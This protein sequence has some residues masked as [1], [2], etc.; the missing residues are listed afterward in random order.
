MLAGESQPECQMMSQ[1]IPF[2][3]PEEMEFAIGMRSSFI[4]QCLHEW[5]NTRIF[6]REVESK[7]SARN[8]R[9]FVSSALGQST[10]LRRHTDRWD[11]EDTLDETMED[12][13]AQFSMDSER[14]LR[15]SGPAAYEEQVLESPARPMNVIDPIFWCLKRRGVDF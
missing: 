2:N 9:Y 7:F 11:D 4:R 15:V 5:D 13:S 10:H 12:P 8:I 3:N 14:D 1:P 6:A